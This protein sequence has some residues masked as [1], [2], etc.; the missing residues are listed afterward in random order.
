MDIAEA[1]SYFLD[2]IHCLHDDGMDYELDNDESASEKD[3]EWS[4]FEGF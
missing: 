2:M 3:D 1:N 4:K